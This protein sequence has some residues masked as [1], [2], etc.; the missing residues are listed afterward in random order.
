MYVYDVDVLQGNQSSESVNIMKKNP[1]FGIEKLGQ[2]IW[3]DFIDRGMIRSGEL[4]RLM[5]E[6]GIR[7]VTSKPS[8]FETAITGSNDYD[9]AIQSLILKNKSI[10]E[11]YTSLTVHDIQ[12]AADVLRPVYDR[13]HG[14][15]GYV[16]LDVSPKLAR[17]TDGTIAEARRLWAEV[18]RPNVLIRVPATT[19]GIPAIRQLLSE[20]Y[21][22]NVTLLFGL[23]RY[24]EVV[25]AYFSGLEERSAHGLDVSTIASVASFFLSRIDTIIDPLLEEEMRIDSPD[26]A[27]AARL[28]GQAAIASAKLAYQIY[29]ELFSGERFQRLAQKDARVQRL[30]WASTSTKNPAY[31]DVRYVEPLIGPD[32]ITALPADTLKAYRDHGDPYETISHGIE[33][34]HVCMERLQRMGFS[35]EN[36]TQRLEDQGIRKFI[37]AYDRALNALKQK[38][39][40]AS[41]AMAR[42]TRV[43]KKNYQ[44]SSRTT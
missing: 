31:T 3:L 22:I 19:Q 8:I 35:F 23:R 11:I 17:D 32:T 7:G 43:K 28:E 16:S 33:E 39:E 10:E 27:R 14:G 40:S 21:N 38:C 6:D 42:G 30:L 20:G 9:T 25:E 26:V 2:S 44:A 29:R 34:A 15:D 4:E 37:D 5:E 1:F 12:S 41:Q 24:R 36:I 18:N 13:L